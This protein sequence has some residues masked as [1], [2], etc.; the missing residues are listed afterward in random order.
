MTALAQARLNTVAG[1]ADG[2]VAF[3]R[4]LADS[5]QKAAAFRRTYAELSQLSDR[6]LDD[7]G[8]SRWEIAE[9]ARTSV[10]GA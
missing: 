4:A 2:V 10:Y 1:L 8:V 5:A 3:V 6:E 9:V 7:L